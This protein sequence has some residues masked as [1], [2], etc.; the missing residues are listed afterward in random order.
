MPFDVIRF[1]D[2]DEA[3]QFETNGATWTCRLDSY[4]CTRSAELSR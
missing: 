2:E 3:L 4:A 1:T